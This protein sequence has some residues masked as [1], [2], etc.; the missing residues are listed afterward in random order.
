MNSN[1]EGKKNLDKENND[2]LMTMTAEGKKKVFLLRLPELRYSRG[3]KS[4]NS[5]RLEQTLV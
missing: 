3:S 4:K 1:V 5:R 2:E